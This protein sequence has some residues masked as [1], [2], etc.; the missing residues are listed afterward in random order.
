MIQTTV[1]ST[2][3]A[4][5]FGLVPTRDEY[6]Y[7][8]PLPNDGFDIPRSRKQAVVRNML[9]QLVPEVC[10]AAGIQGRKT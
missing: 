7:F 4:R 2:F 1:L 8:W 9:A 5:Y 6:F 10:K 3:F